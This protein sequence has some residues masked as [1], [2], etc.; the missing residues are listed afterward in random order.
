MSLALKMKGVFLSPKAKLVPAAEVKRND[1]RAT[2]FFVMTYILIAF[3]F[4]EMALA[5]GNPIANMLNGAINF[6]N[7]DVMRAVGIIA[8][9]SLGFM[10]YFGRLSWEKAGLIMV[11]LVC[12]FGAAG[13]VDQFSGYVN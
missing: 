12:T 8:V 4:P 11:G 1:K 6:I 5:Q 13:L 7:S 3:L 2:K 9:I 10:A